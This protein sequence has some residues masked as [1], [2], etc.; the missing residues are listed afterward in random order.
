MKTLFI[1]DAVR[2][3]ATSLGLEEKLN[4]QLSGGDGVMR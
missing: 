1:D 2:I 4:D 3:R